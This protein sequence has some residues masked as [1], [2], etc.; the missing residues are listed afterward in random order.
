VH[1][2]LQ[3]YLYGDFRDLGQQNIR[4]LR[5]TPGCNEDEDMEALRD[6]AEDECEVIMRKA[7]GRGIHKTY[8]EMDR[9]LEKIWEQ[10]M[11]VY[12]NPGL[13][14]PDLFLGKE[15]PPVVTYRRSWAWFQEV[16]KHLEEYLQHSRR[17]S[18]REHSLTPPR[19]PAGWRAGRRRQQPQLHQQQGGKTNQLWTRLIGGWMDRAAGWYELAPLPVSR[20]W[21]WW[22]DIG[23]KVTVS[24]LA[25]PM[26]LE[27]RWW[28]GIGLSLLRVTKA[29][30][31]TMGI[32]NCA[33]VWHEIRIPGKWRVG[34]SPSV[35]QVHQRKRIEEELMER[36]VGPGSSR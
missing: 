21:R 28:E 29:L 6:I 26:V 27:I 16:S 34:T 32:G 7:R 11:V 15:E 31:S 25:P 20:F 17:E 22:E 30:Q 36:R 9:I 3:V 2:S 4:E 5:R 23:L 13:K 14:G 12:N 24:Q 10:K 18:R 33:D 35:P 1:D 8:K 19:N